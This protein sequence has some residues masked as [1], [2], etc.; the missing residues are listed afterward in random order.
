M[1]LP[2][3]GSIT[4]FTCPDCGGGIWEKSGEG[5]LSFECRIGHTFAADEM[6]IDHA[7]MR[8]EALGAA[9]RLMYEHAAVQRRLE[10]WAREQGRLRAA[11]Q[12][13]TEAA[14][15][16]AQGQRLRRLLERA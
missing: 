3:D 12:F 1:T 4:G 14:T 5:S 9:V 7:R 13:A 16:E 8:D 10:H 6:L 2:K 11:D 15:Y